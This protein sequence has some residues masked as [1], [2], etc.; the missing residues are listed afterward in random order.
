[1]WCCEIWAH[2]LCRERRPTLPKEES[3]EVAAEINEFVAVSAD[4]AFI[5]LKE[6]GRGASCK[7]GQW[8]IYQGNQRPPRLSKVGDYAE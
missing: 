7:G 8:S 3:G 1:M 2:D 4:Q 5:T 6:Q